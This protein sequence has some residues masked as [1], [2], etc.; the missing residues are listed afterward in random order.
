M[1]RP[2]TIGAILLTATVS[3][4]LYQLSYEVQRLEDELVEYNH[5]LLRERETIQVLHAEWSYLTR[6]EALQERAARNLQLEPLLPSH[7]VRISELPDRAPGEGVGGDTE[8]AL[9]IPLPKPKFKLPPSSAPAQV[10]EAGRRT[11]PPARLL[12]PPVVAVAVG[13]D[14]IDRVPV[15]ASAKVQ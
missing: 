10:A 2:L 3:F 9:P 6:P 13:A 8:P 11:M 15:L 7:I 5:A 4:G 1:S 12:P 14:A